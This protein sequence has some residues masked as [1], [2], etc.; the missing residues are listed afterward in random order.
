MAIEQR[1]KTDNEQHR[2]MTTRLRKALKSV[3]PLKGCQDLCDEWEQV[4]AKHDTEVKRLEDGIR[5]AEAHFRYQEAER[6]QALLD[7]LS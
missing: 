6:L 1:S 2:E 3:S 7:A 4:H 5:K